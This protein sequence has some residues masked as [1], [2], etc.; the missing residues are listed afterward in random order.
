MVVVVVVE[1]SSGG[2]CKAVV[3]TSCMSVPSLWT[4]DTMHRQIEHEHHHQILHHHPHS[5]HQL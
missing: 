2:G 5:A 4:A 1:E 3:L